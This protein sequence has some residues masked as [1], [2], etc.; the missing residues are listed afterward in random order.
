MIRYIAV[1]SVV[2]AM[3]GVGGTWLVL[4]YGNDT[5]VAF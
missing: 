2:G 3:L 5:L 4:M 1:G